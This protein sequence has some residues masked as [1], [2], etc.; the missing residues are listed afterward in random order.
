MSSHVVHGYGIKMKTENEIKSWSFTMN[1][2]VKGCWY[3]I[4]GN[5]GKE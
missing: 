5:W 3:L 2:L 4:D 1:S